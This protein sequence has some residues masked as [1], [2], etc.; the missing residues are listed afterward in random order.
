MA[1]PINFIVAGTRIMRTMVASTKMAVARPR[2]ISLAAGSLLRTKPRNTEIM[3]RAAEVITRAVLAM[4]WITEVSLSRLIR[5]FS[6]TR[7]SR[8]TS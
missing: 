6:R 3:I 1:S 2:P 4:P 8:K 5:Y 7:D